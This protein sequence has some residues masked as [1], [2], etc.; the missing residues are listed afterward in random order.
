MKARLR[1]NHKANKKISTYR[2]RMRK[3]IDDSVYIDQI[4][5]ESSKQSSNSDI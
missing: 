4:T 2:P 1:H 5:D 3:L